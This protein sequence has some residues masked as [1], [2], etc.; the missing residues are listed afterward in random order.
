M[1]DFPGYEE[2]GGCVFPSPFGDAV[3]DSEWIRALAPVLP[4]HH[5]LRQAL[6]DRR[7]S[8][9]EDFRGRGA[10]IPVVGW[11]VRRWQDRHDH[12]E[13][14]L[15]NLRRPLRAVDAPVV[16]AFAE[17]HGHLVRCGLWVM[18]ARRSSGG[19]YGLFDLFADYRP[20]AIRTLWRRRQFLGGVTSLFE[21]A[22]LLDVRDV[23][24]EDATVTL[25]EMRAVADALQVRALHACLSD[26]EVS[27]LSPA[28]RAAVL[29]SRDPNP[30]INAQ[31]AD[32][33]RALE[34]E[35]RRAVAI[36]T[37]AELPGSSR[38]LPG[39]KR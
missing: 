2:E 28:W 30:A 11:V 29:T 21:R 14:S 9:A 10:R 39:G 24:P 5:Q 1:R 7:R 4:T 12:V 33:A 27:S 35:R 31:A 19:W 37:V 8:L 16:I 3:R 15:G 38:I 22:L 36:R 20:R 17:V 34:D 6:V 25:G 18:R 26:D 32:A 23:D 13:R